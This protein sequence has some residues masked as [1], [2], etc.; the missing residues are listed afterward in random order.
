MADPVIVFGSINMDLVARVPRLPIP[1]ETLLG[2]GFSTVPGGKGANQ[3]VAIVRLG[4]P[5][6]MVGRVGGDQFGENLLNG[7][8]A[9][10]IQTE[11]VSTDTSVSSGMA[12]IAVDDR[13]ENQIIVIAGANGNVNEED[14][15]R[16]IPHLSHATALLLQLEIPIA[17]VKLAAQA[18]KKAGVTVI[19]DPAPA[20]E[21]PLDL[22]PL[23]DIITPNAVEAEQL[24]GFPIDS[25]SLTSEAAS[26][27]QKRGVKTVILKLGAKGGFCATSEEAFFFPAFEVEAIDTVAAG[28]AFNGGLAAALAEGHSIREAVTWGAA[29]GALSTTKSG[30]QG[31]LPDREEVMKLMGRDEG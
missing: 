10:K 17:A 24:V 27:L 16:L 31:A 18:A 7:L 2:Q 11:D 20:S 30:A 29:T 6:I 12:L 9:A 19:L 15:T 26:V 8:K 5:A 28:D 14:V 25:P 1:G 21:I 4:I 22:Y 23:I 13:S 3:A